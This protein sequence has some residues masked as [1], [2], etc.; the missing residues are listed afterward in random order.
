MV[1]RVVEAARSAL[2]VLGR[3][4]GVVALTV[5]AAVLRFATLDVQSFWRDEAVTA[6]QVLQPGLSET[7]TVAP[8]TG[9][10]PPFYYVLA[11]CWSKLFGTGEVGL[12]SLSALVGTATVP[13]AYGAAFRISRRTGLIAA[14]LTATNPMLVWYSQEVGPYSLLVF[15]AALSFLLFV[16]ALERPSRARLVGWAVFSALALVTHY[17]AILVVAPQAVWLVASSGERRRKAAAVGAT[18]AAALAVLPLALQQAG[19]GLG[20]WIA[21]IEL[22][23]RLRD[24][25]ENFLVGGG[26]AQIDGL[27]APTAVLA[28]AGLLLLAVRSDRAEQRV[29]LI[30]FAIGALAVGFALAL[31][32]L[33]VDHLLDRN[34]LPALFPLTVA[35][36]AG[37]GARRAGP[38]GIIAAGALCAVFSL[39]VVTT[40]T[41]KDLQRPDWRGVAAALGDA[42]QTRVIVAP[43]HAK[44]PLDIYLPNARD[45]RAD[46]PPPPNID[47]QRELVEGRYVPAA[48][49]SAREVVMIGEAKPGSPVPHPPTGFTRTQQ[50]T[51]GRLGIA[52][53][54]SPRPVELAPWA[55]STTAVGVPA[56]ATVLIEESQRSTAAG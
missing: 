50:R 25:A 54:R 56:G 48:R 34:L 10:D 22:S 28:C 43:P 20:G 30:A 26:P 9:F 5:L 33:G 7:L 49:T 31:A 8:D 41:R 27:V 45:L 17:F 47:P 23:E 13:V 39:I 35:L 44:Q 16:G 37:F 46:T 32:G 53:F 51:V 6:G 18:V 11:W 42:T 2:G 52:I 14:A 55:L 24:L 12:R 29:G 4:R 19:S 36:A 21:T 15:L 1:R 3:H 38:V 40:A